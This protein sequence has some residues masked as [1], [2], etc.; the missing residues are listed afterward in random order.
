MPRR[1]RPLDPGDGELLRFAGDLRRL[2]REAGSPTYRTLA[3]RAHY[4]PAALSEAA[5]GRKLPTLD[6]T[7]AYVRA[8]GGDAEGWRRRWNALAAELAHGASPATGDE[9]APYVG[10][11]PFGPSDADLFFG[12]ERLVADLLA[13]LAERRFLACFGASGA[14]K[15]SLLRAGVLPAWRRAHPDGTGVLLT[16]GAHPLEECAI[17][18]AAATGGTPAPIRA[19]LAADPRGLH[20]LVR[21]AL[22]PE[23]GGPELLLMVDQFEEVF[24]LCRETDERARFIGALLTAAREEN[25]RCRVV[26]GVRADFYAYCARHPELVAALNDAQV[27]VGPMTLDE[28]RRAISEPAVRSGYAIESG[29]LTALV[30]GAHDRVGVLPLLSHA[31]LETWRR[32]RGT[33]LTLA[34]FQAAGGVDDALARTAEAAYAALPPAQQRLTRLLF[35]RLTALG[36]GTEDTKRRVPYAELSGSDPDVRQVLDGLARH[37]LLTLDQD[38]VEITH[39]ALIRCWPRLRDWLAEDREGLRIHRRL[40]DA[41]TGWETLDHD[42]GALYR[43]ARLDVASGWA[44]QRDRG[45]SPLE[46]RFLAA[47]QVVREAEER[48]ARRQARRLR[49][50][51]AALSILLVTASGAAVLAARAQRATSQQRDIVTSQRVAERAASLRRFQPA[52]AAQLGLAAYRLAPTSQARSSLLSSLTSPYATIVESADEVHAVAVSPDGRTLATAGQ[53]RTVVL[54]DIA[55][56]HRPRHAATLAGAVRGVAF[57]TGGTALAAAT[58]EGTVKL[59]DVADRA[60]PQPLPMT[61]PTGR[62]AAVACGPDGRAPVTP[63]AGEVRA[64]SPDGRVL[65]TAGSGHRV[66]LWDATDPARPRPL[67]TAAGH[68]DVVKAMAFAP[69]GRTLISGGI[70]ATVRLWDVSDPRRPRGLMTLGGH[71]AAVNSVAVMPD[72]HTV[73]S[74]SADHTT[75]LWDVPGPALVGHES[76]VYTAAFAPDGNTVATAGY[77]TTIRLWSTADR[78]RPEASATLQGHTGPVNAVAFRPDGRTLASAGHDATVR[79][80]DVSE[81]RGPRPLDVVRHPESVESL[82]WSPDGRLLASAS[83]DRLVRLWS[84]AD[85]TRPLATLAGHTGPVSTLAFS[86]DGRMLATAGADRTIRLWALSDPGRPVGVA[87]LSGHGDTVTS[88]A[89]HPGGHTLASGGEDRTVRLWDVSDPDRPGPLVTAGWYG[90]GVKAVRFSPDGRTLATAVSD[91]TLRLWAVTDP[92]R[93]SE[94]AVLTGHTKPVDAVA[95]SPDGHSLVSGAEDWTGLLWDT[96]PGRVATRVCALAAAPL[97]RSVWDQ[98]FAGLPYRPPCP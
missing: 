24:T 92:R 84:P 15:S 52:L 56:P 57:C 20:R 12:R 51:V 32:R 97:S 29:L 37:R 54:W 25:G 76:S 83:H 55:D 53:D 88:V 45:L 44:A 78:R 16:P 39:E 10:L 30:A 40:T 49:A 2:R 89:F 5:G 90:D 6:V 17:A 68:T 58:E 59:W 11:A 23:P 62:A 67:A 80:W 73:V 21:Q 3:D 79:L 81:S 18:L 7:L 4:S 35:L 87:V 74:G 64:L 47:S 28:L 22:G 8:C 50:L 14:G 77:D 70:D 63:G 93:P 86:P 26:L 34:G 96:D 60:R 69:D 82:A 42:P 85:L 66:R 94:V 61:E 13:R 46:T 98:Y 9:R 95:F 38:S 71:T 48:T 33:M 19:Q 72:G 1:E 31:L 36:E 75:R 65:A 43:G 27:A 91:H 41:A